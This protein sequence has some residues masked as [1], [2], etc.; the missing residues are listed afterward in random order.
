MKFS[1]QPMNI[2]NSDRMLAGLLQ[3]APTGLGP[4]EWFTNVDEI[5]RTVDMEVTATVSSVQIDG[6]RKLVLKDDGPGMPPV[7]TSEYDLTTF[8]TTVGVSGNY[9]DTTSLTQNRGMGMRFAWTAHNPE[10]II[11]LSKQA[12]QPTYQAGWRFDAEAERYYPSLPEQVDNPLSISEST[13]RRS[14]CWA[15]R[16]VTTPWPP[17]SL[18]A[19]STSAVACCSHPC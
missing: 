15:N 11:I 18:T 4:R 6:V 14:S 19:M 9:K 8:V 13:A 12:G 17:R 5:A 10:G 1:D 16:R 3:S 2:G 7:S